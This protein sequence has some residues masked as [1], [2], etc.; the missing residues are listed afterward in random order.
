MKHLFNVQTSIKAGMMG[1]PP[2]GPNPCECCETMSAIHEE[3]P[4]PPPELVEEVDA[5]CGFEPP[6]E[7]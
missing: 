1:P 5:I 6:P 3:F 4:P 7:V 2:E